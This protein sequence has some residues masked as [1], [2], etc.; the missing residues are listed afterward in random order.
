MKKFLSLFMVL[1]LSLTLS[2]C[3]SEPKV[4]EEKEEVYETYVRGEWVDN[5]YTNNY[6]GFSFT[7]P[8]DWVVVSDEE[9]LNMIEFG[10]SQSNDEEIKEVYEEAMKLSTTFFDFTIVNE[11]TGETLMLIVEDLTKTNS[12]DISI[13]VYIDLMVSNFAKTISY[14]FESSELSE[15]IISNET[16]T[17]L[18]L[19]IENIAIQ[20]MFFLRKGKYIVTLQALDIIDDV[21]DISLIF[22]EM[23]IN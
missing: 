15:V 18:E 14:N 19:N 21:N 16:Y 23:S 20:K 2:A 1:A 10:V 4:E 8:E 17:Y 11:S 22:E 7:L 13:D 5:V 3:S 12:L 6:L 9:L